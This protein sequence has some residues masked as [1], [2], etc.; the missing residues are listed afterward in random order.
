RAILKR[1]PRPFRLARLSL[2]A[3]LSLRAGPA[4]RSALAA[5]CPPLVPPARQHL[6]ALA[7]LSLR[8]GP[9]VRSA[10][11]APCPPLVPPARQRLVALGVLADLPGPVCAP[12]LPPGPTGSSHAASVKPTA[13]KSR[14]RGR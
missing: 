3:P 14:I 4:V 7:P 9:A 11:A 2:L 1:R 10:L 5:P 6:T 13:I 12:C 8:A